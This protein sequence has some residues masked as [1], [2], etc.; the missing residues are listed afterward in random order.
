M[1]LHPRN[2]AVVLAL[3]VFSMACPDPVFGQ[4]R[5]VLTDSQWET[6]FHGLAQV[7][8]KRGI[9]IEPTYQQWKSYPARERI[10]ILMGTVSAEDQRY[11]DG[12]VAAGGSVLLAT[13]T[14]FGPASI[15]QHRIQITDGGRI[16]TLSR[17]DGLGGQREWPIIRNF[18]RTHPLFDGIDWIVANEPAQ[19]LITP[20]TAAAGWTAIAR[21]PL[22][23]NQLPNRPFVVTFESPTGDGRLLIIP[24]HS[25]YVNGS[26]N[27]GDNLRFLLNTVDWIRQGGQRKHCLFVLNGKE[28]V[29][30]NVSNV[31]LYRPPPGASETRRLLDQLW[32]NT[33]TQEKLEL[34]NEALEF[35]QEERLLEELVDSINLNDIFSPNRQL[36]ILIVIG[37]WL[38]IIPFIVCLVS[39]RKKP[40]ESG[41]ADGLIPDLKSEQQRREKLERFRAAEALFVHVFG[42][43]GLPANSP[44][45]VD[46][47]C[48]SVADDPQETRS[49]RSRIRKIQQ[50]LLGRPVEYWSDSRVEEVGRHVA[51]WINLYETGR[52][53]IDMEPST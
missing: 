11:I 31:E 2:L 17:G 14:D 21:F 10:L 53:R 50:D 39:N 24:D 38:I 35:A 4:D 15:D 8:R 12:F 49:L 26:L 13:D 43:I 32:Q 16:Q 22:L 44:Q 23:R 28:V 1:R 46:P 9:I 3:V 40:L 51:Q 30:L 18:D 37:S 20:R 42:R 48:L 25:I 29:P 36:A 7:M 33:N 45:D 5:M 47:E 41:A 19:I 52:L 6:G 27:V 34:A